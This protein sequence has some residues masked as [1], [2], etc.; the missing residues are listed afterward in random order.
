MK[1][2]IHMDIQ[3]L[4][5]K[6]DVMSAD[7]LFAKIVRHNAGIVGSDPASMIAVRLVLTNGAELT[8]RPVELDQSKNAII[9]SKAELSYVNVSTMSVLE[10]LDPD[11]A[12]ALITNEPPPPPTTPIVPSSSPARSELRDELAKLNT[13]MQN[14]FHLTINAEVLDDATLGDLGK[15]QFVDF[16]EML[17]QA[18]TDIGS[19]DVGEI[20][21][22]SLDQILLAQAPG[23][24][25]VK[26]SGEL[27][28]IAVPFS[29]PFEE[30]LSARLQ[31]ELQTTL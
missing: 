14:R 18:L 4:G 8:G 16:L 21:V 7:A 2:A 27:L 24:L 26:R 23:Q 10:I 3:L 30:T 25:A 22:S 29:E 1:G 31:T 9:A 17:D 5:P 20:T 28:L 11:A 19:T 12:A 6:L 15:N 13:K